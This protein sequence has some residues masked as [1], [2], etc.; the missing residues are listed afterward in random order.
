MPSP[1]GSEGE[2][3]RGRG[4]EGREGRRDKMVGGDGKRLG[5]RGILRVGE[6]ALRAILVC[7]GLFSVESN[8]IV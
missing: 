2:G 6:S 5:I 1:G 3:R 4:V 7:D 8:S